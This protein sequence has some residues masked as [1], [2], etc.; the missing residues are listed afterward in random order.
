LSSASFKIRFEALL[1]F[2]GA[3]TLAI[4][5]ISIRAK[6]RKPGSNKDGSLNFFLTQKKLRS[7]PL[8][9]ISNYHSG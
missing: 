2:S 7:L 5:V 6:S 9:K 1:L 3:L 4:S 8:P